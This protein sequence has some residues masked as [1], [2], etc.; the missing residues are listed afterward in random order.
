MKNC[1]MKKKL[2][3]IVLIGWVALGLNSLL[4]LMG[5]KHA[6]EGIHELYADHLTSSNQLTNIMD[7][8]H[9][10][11]TQ[12]LL[13]LQHDPNGVF[14]KMHN[15]PTEMH[16]D[17]VQKNFDELNGLLNKMA[18]TPCEDES[19]KLKEAFLASCKKLLNEGLIPVAQAAKQQDF[20][21]GGILTLQKINTIFPETEKAADLVLAHELECAKAAYTHGVDEYREKTITMVIALLLSILFSGGISYLIIRAIAHLTERLTQAAEVIANGD[22]THRVNSECHDELGKVAHSFDAMADTITGLISTTQKAVL[23]LAAST[24]QFSGSTNRIAANTSN[25]AEQAIIIATSSEE[26]SVTSGEIAQNCSM[27]AQGAQFANDRATAGAEVVRQT[28]AGMEKISERVKDTA[29]TVESLGERS[30]QIGEIVETIQDIADQTNLLALNAAIEAARAGEMGRGFAVVADEVRALAE[31]TTRAT[32]EISEMIHAI[33]SETKGAVKSMEEGVQ[34]V[35]EGTSRAARSGEALGEILNQIDLVSSQVNQIATAAEQQTATTTEISTKIQDIN[36]VAQ[37]ASATAHSGALAATELAALAED[38]QTMVRQFKTPGSELFILE[39]AK[40]DHKL[41]VETVEQIVEG[42]MSM[43]ASQL[44]TH[45]T[46]RFGKWYEGEGKE[47]CGHLSAFKSIEIPHER[48]H[49]LA[50]EIVTVAKSGQQDKAVAML[51]ELMDLSRQIS[52]LI[53]T[54]ENE[55]NRSNQSH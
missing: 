50:R 3:V 9:M 8:L 54:L 16:L 14:A 26:M 12:L 1:S 22:L 27:A 35:Q 19:K 4:G 47:L 23:K 32:R 17:N 20:Y 55:A 49:A 24:K 10:S 33:Q 11:R 18:N 45:K 41:F 7:L 52:S 21:N 34:E 2:A 40:N 39:L 43:E 36:S 38:L 51:S 15:H 48:I 28:I 13:A 42:L 6:N 25:M 5:M 30:D 37:N 46:C 29:R 31:R 44:A 53:D